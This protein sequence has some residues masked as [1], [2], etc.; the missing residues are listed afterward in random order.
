MAK[1]K[2]STVEVKEQKIENE[3]TVI[4]VNITIPTKLFHLAEALQD[5][6]RVES[7]E[8]A[9]ES[10]IEN[11]YEKIYQIIAPEKPTQENKTQLGRPKKSAQ[12]TESNK[13]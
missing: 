3:S 9:F 5:V 10:G 7:L 11:Y 1:K 6:G 4:S 2:I 12:V 8:K 13:N